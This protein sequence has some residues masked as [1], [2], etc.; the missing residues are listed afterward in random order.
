VDQYQDDLGSRLRGVRR[1]Q[2]LTLA[3]VEERSAGEWKAV[4][5]GSY[6]RGD[7]S[8]TVARLAEIAMFYGV[9]MSHLLPPREQEFQEQTDR[10]A[11][12][13]IQL[14]ALADQYQTLAR[15]VRR[16]QQERGDYNGRIL[17]LRNDDLHMVATA[18]GSN[19]DA[20]LQELRERA[21]I[22]T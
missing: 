18:E 1:M 22:L 12:D 11:V 17:T 14:E 20:L 10:L 7:R 15:Y 8:M 19:P 2:G 5:V 9:P 16:I 3:D 13:L 21:L 6:E 4:V